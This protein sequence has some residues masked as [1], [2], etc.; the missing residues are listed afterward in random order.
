MLR[1]VLHLHSWVTFS[2]LTEQTVFFPCTKSKEPLQRAKWQRWT[3]GSWCNQTLT[4]WDCPQFCDI[5]ALHLKHETVTVRFIAWLLSIYSFSI[6]PISKLHENEIKM[7]IW[8]HGQ[9]S[10][11]FS[12]SAENQTP[13]PRDNTGQWDMTKTL[14]EIGLWLT[15]WQEQLYGQHLDLAEK[16]NDLWNIHQIKSFYFE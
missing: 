9:M 1:L 14:G 5:L 12:T 13:A 2:N 16:W 6:V 7:V 3:M 10:Y 15:L 4:A 8:I 11:P